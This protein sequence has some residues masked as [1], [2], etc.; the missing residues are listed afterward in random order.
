[1]S[2]QTDSTTLPRLPWLVEERK[3]DT[4]L[5]DTKSI[6]RW[7]NWQVIAAFRGLVAA[8][9]F[10]ASRSISTAWRDYDYRVIER[11]QTGQ[12]A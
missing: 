1:M 11:K 10:I 12:A 5:F 4:T 3:K 9:N 2:E 8:N 6:E 7:S